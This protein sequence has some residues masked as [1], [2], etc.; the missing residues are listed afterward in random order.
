M[1]CNRVKRSRTGAAGAA[2]VSSS[3][4]MAGAVLCL[5]VFGC[6]GGARVEAQQSARQAW[7]MPAANPIIQ[8]GDMREKGIWN[9]PSVVRLDDG[10][11]AMYLTTSTVEPFKPPILPFRALSKDGLS[12][13]LDPPGPLLQPVAPYI[14]I[15]TPSVVRFKGKWHMYYMGVMPPGSVPASHIGHAVSDDGIRWRHD[16]AGTRVIAA[17]GKVTDWNGFLV[18]EPGAVVYK[19]RIYVYFAA[20][21][22]RPGLKP[23]QLSTIGLATSADG[24]HFDEPR[25]VLSADESIFPPAKGYA[26]Y[27]TVSAVVDQGRMHLFYNVVSNPKLSGSDVE[28]VALHHSSSA[29]GETGWRQ[30]PRPIFDRS[31]FDWT[32]GGGII[33]PSVIIENGKA[34]MWFAGHMSKSSFVKLMLGGW[35]GR[36]FGVGYAEAPASRALDPGR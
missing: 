10:L 30:D 20:L 22:A 6:G 17:T 33:S 29:D 21:G 9:D 24:T 5:A 15:E 4:R 13:R 14:N 36:Q 16:P 2:R 7:S 34:R 19:D 28:Q 31:D 8:A 27:A 32:D 1:A 18:S 26:G 25:R 35:K 12:W 11:Y 23:P 3:I